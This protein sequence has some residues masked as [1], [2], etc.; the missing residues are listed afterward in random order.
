MKQLRT[1]VCVSLCGAML[2]G[3][4]GSD[5][6]MRQPLCAL[7]GLVAG[8]GAGYG[9]Y[10][11]AISK[12]HNQDEQAAAAAGGAVLGATVGALLCADKGTPPPPPPPAECKD[13]D[14]DGV[15]DDRDSCL[16]TPAGVAVDSKGCPL[17][18][19]NDGVP[20]DKDKCPNTPAGVEVDADG[21]PKAGQT[22]MTLEGVNFAFNSAKLTPDAETVLNQAVQA[23]ND[24][25][26]VN[27]QVEG[28]TDSVGSDAYNKKLSQKRAAAVVNYLA[29]RGISRNRM[30][31]VGMGESEPVASN[32]T[33]DGRYKN[34]RVVF[35][36]TN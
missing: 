25:G 23:L 31:P 11:A 27:V 13:T 24:A 10:E 22:L 6:N 1:L 20:D 21:C 28:H 29:S 2:A 19:D 35:K 14:S 8:G 17:D 34:R 30:E 3:C 32:S 36:V 26:S 9:I 15:C 33:A 7:G 5:P 4:A 12:K 18:S 16:D